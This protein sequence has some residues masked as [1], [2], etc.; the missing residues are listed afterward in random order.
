MFFDTIHQALIMHTGMNTSVDLSATT[1]DIST[2]SL[3]Y[4]YT[5]INWGNPPE[6]QKLVWLGNHFTIIPNTFL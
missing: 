6:L 4:T 2:T 1:A 5:I 3:V